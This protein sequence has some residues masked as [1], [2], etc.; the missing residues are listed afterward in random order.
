ME[1]ASTGFK[2]PERIYGAK[3]QNQSPKKPTLLSNSSQSQLT[4]YK[5]FGINLGPE[6]AV[7]PQGKFIPTR[8]A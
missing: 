2:Y 8:M 1:F 6:R 7:V 4:R 5:K 3:F